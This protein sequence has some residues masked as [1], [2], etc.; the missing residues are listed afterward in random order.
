MK[1]RLIFISFL[2]T[3]TLSSGQ[4]AV[5]SLEAR[6]HAS[7]SQISGSLKTP[8]LKQPVRV[9]RDRWGVAHIYASNQHDLFFAQGFVAAQDRLFQMELWKRSG[10]GRLAEVLGPTALQRD[11]NAR[12][13]M[14]RGNMKT[15][16]ESYAPDT[17][18]IL[19]AF[20]AGINAFIARRTT[21]GGPSLPI[22]FEL[23]GFKP[24]PWK[25][26]D[27]LNRMAAFS[28]TGNSF[29]ELTH[30]QM[31]A[32]LGAEKASGMFEFDPPVTLDPA[33]KIDFAGFSPEL[34]KDVVGSDVRIEFPNEKQ[35]SNNWTVS[36]SLT[37]SGKPL[38]ANDPHRVIAEP[39]L[40]YMVHLVAPGWDV[41]GGGEPGLPGVALGH[42]QHIA[43][44]FTIFAL[45]Q[46]DLYLEKLNPANPLQYRSAQ[47]WRNMRVEKATFQVRGQGPVTV[48]LKFTRHGPVMWEDG[49]RALALRWVGA[50]P[51]AA[52]YLASLSVDRASSWDDFEAAMPRWKVPPENIVYADAE[53]NI[54]EHSTGLVPVRKNWTGLLPVPGNG[55]YEWSG[56]VANDELPHQ[57]NPQAGFV[58]SANHKMIPAGYPY[59]V[60][61]E[62]E[63]R[64]RIERISET[65]G[66]ARNYGRKLSVA[67]MEK[68]QTD[69]VSL[70]ALEL[71]ALLQRAGNNS[72]A[73]SQMMLKWDG[74]LSRDSGPGALYELWRR[75]LT[76]EVMKRAVPD[77]YRNLLEDWMPSQVLRKLEHPSKE[78]FGEERAAGRNQ[79]LHE[80]L[81]A[82]ETKLRALQGD[83]PGKWSW[84][85]LHVMRFRHP[86]DQ[87]AGAEKFLDLGPLPR[88]GDDYTVNATGFRGD[89]FEQGSGASYREILDTSDWDKSVAIN[90]P[91]QSGQPGSPHY[92][93]LLPLWGEGKYFP[94]VYSR[95]AVEKAT[96]DKLELIP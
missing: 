89:S 92:S 73:T 4:T 80:T 74:V 6:T 7:L 47:G 81:A 35:G 60:G 32:A 95:E 18:E 55:R 61:Y 63:P 78:M 37:K 57:Y 76:N 16:Y 11:V 85:A 20:T 67:D 79:L 43:W 1:A 41:I 39:S 66:A 13:L 33:P 75:E 3:A 68:L 27:C 93:D 10:Q 58:A 48:D 23:A 87:T 94:L 22:E 36:G 83:D 44:G 9:L 52:G 24:E 49:K 45:D 91:G 84:G 42:N 86:L 69:V 96:T 46:Q 34:L 56:F 88:P 31:V 30:A 72:D 15:E 51:G 70:P 77:K 64:F 19:E 8:G 14:Y 40:R 38:L 53:G 82:A 62:W 50:E 28:M 2:L 25:P 59:K 17:K 54:G 21:A 5:S 26:E 65:L 12:R 90:T 29:S 71:I